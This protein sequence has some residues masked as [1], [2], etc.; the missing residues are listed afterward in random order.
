MNY[1][2]RLKTIRKK[3]DLSQKQLGD[4]LGFHQGTV[5]VWEKSSYPPL[6]SI[7]KICHLLK[8]PL[9]EFFLTDK[10]KEDIVPAGIDPIQV[11]IL[12]EIN[13]LPAKKRKLIHEMLIKLFELMN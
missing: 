2:E 13:R 1:G 5:S 3:A 4:K 11:K 8:I 10:D 6:D 7:E 9:Y 12:Q